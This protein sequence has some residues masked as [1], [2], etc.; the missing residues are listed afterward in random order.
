M[1]H[2]CHEEEGIAGGAEG[3]G[4]GQCPNPLKLEQQ[5]TKRE[6][7]GEPAARAHLTERMFLAPK[8]Q[9]PSAELRKPHRL[10]LIC[11]PGPSPAGA[12]HRDSRNRSPDLVR[13]QS[14]GPEKH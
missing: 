9:H 12:T 7:A 6:P 14:S 4:P 8:L 10:K 2:G 13:S 11:S 3:N 1:L 5:H